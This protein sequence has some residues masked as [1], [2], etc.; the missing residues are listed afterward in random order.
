MLGA[1]V[2]VRGREEFTMSFVP[3][4]LE[5]AQSIGQVSQYYDSAAWCK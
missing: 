4:C 5:G 1:W 2:G 3:I